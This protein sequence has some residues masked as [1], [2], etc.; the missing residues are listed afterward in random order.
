MVSIPP[1][2]SIHATFIPVRL[3][4]IIRRLHFRT[5][6]DR[7]SAGL[8]VGMSLKALSWRTLCGFRNSGVRTIRAV[9][10]MGMWKEMMMRLGSIR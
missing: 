9:F 6:S 7:P 1:H 10:K 4:L 3:L 8:L 5:D 2:D